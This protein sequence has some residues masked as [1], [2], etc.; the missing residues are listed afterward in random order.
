MN[1]NLLAE[2]ETAGASVERVT[3]NVH[4]RLLFCREP[5]RCRMPEVLLQH[6]QEPEGVTVLAL[7]QVLSR[8]ETWQ[9]LWPRRH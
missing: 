1:C 2:V 4:S 3:Y 7:L 9:K 5:Q 6:D 8:L